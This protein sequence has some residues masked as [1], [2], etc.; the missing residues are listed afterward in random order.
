VLFRSPGVDAKKSIFSRVSGWEFE[1]TVVEC[2]IN[3]CGCFLICVS[4]GGG[5]AGCRTAPSW[6]NVDILIWRSD[7]LK[8]K[9]TK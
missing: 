8:E 9:D 1:Q 7:R 2:E 6:W 4:T 3:V 5:L